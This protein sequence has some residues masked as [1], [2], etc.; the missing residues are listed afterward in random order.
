MGIAAAV[1]TVAE[2]GIP[3]KMSWR[4]V[5]NFGGGTVVAG[6]L[7]GGLYAAPLPEGEGLAAAYHGDE[8]IDELG[9]GLVQDARKALAIEAIGR[10]THRTL[11]NVGHVGE[12]AAVG[13]ES[14][15]HRGPA[16]A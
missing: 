6:I 7:G 14:A 2:Q 8:G 11:A 16:G 9:L 15:G 10:L 12:H 3:K 5:R 1:E 4:C 13:R